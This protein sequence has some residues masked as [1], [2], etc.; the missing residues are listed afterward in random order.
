[1]EPRS[2]REHNKAGFKVLHSL[3]HRLGRARDEILTGT[4]LQDLLEQR[5]QLVQ[6]PVMALI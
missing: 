2:S 6:A 5:N 1:M 3:E 4:R